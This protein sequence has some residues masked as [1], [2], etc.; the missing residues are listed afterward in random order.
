MI[1]QERDHAYGGIPVRERERQLFGKC[2]A[3]IRLAR[4]QQVSHH[5]HMAQGMAGVFAASDLRFGVIFRQRQVD[6]RIAGRRLD[7]DFNFHSGAGTHGAESDRN[8]RAIFRLTDGGARR[9][10]IT[11]HDVAPAIHYQLRRIGRLEMQ[12]IDVVLLAL[13]KDRRGEAVGPAQAVPVIDVFAENN[14]IGA[15]HGLGTI[16]NFQK[17]VGRRTTRTSLGCEQFQQDGTAAGGRNRAGGGEQSCRNRYQKPSRVDHASPVHASPFPPGTYSRFITVWMV[18]PL[19]APVKPTYRDIADDTMAAGFLMNESGQVKQCCAALYQS[20]LAR[21]LLGESFHPGGLRLTLRLGELL[22][23]Q[24]GW[25]VLDA[26]SGKGESALFVARQFGCE[27]TGIDFGAANVAEATVRA[28]E[29]GLADKVHFVTGDAEE[30]AASDGSFDAVICE[31]A[32]CTFPDKRA[33]A[34]EFA[35][36][37]RPGGRIGLSDL[38]RTGPLPPELESLLAWVACIADA[39]PAAE[40]VSLLEDAGFT[41]TRVEPR[42][43]AL[44]EMVRDIQGRLMG[45]EL[46]VKL[47]KFDL[48]AADFE[49][50]RTM[51]RSAAE[52]VRS[53]RLGYALI[54]GE[55]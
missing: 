13:G 9:R 45:A 55:R 53:G 34:A 32:F 3:R 50:A 44:A 43:E 46:M 16:E 6:I 54:T 21:L 23:L 51:A 39:L 27:V 29:E 1:L 18:P 38:T 40:Y 31:C 35:R 14:E 10:F 15:G 30:L 33:A 26:A 52:A 25:R 12:S 8:F 17:P 49:Q 48:P 11:A 47:R 4:Q 28:K 20:D 41:A 24:P 36:V 37:L 22:D 42:D 7:T 19:T 5:R 2:A